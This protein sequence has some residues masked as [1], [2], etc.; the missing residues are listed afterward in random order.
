MENISGAEAERI[1]YSEII[2]VNSVR[3]IIIRYMEQP[4]GME[5]G[6]MERTVMRLR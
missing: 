6:I 5:D 4:F 1:R 3:S 2:P